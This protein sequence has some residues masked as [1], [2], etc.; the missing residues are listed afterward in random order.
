[1]LPNSE[2]SPVPVQRLRAFLARLEGESRGY[3]VVKNPNLWANIERGGDWDLLV[4]DLPSAQ[5]H[6]VETLGRPERIS[7]RSYV[8]SHYFDWGE[9]DLLSGIE[10]RGVELVDRDRV[11]RSFRRHGE[12]WRINSLAYEA[13]A[14]WV[15][16]LLYS[17]TFNER[18][19]T[20]IQAAVANEADDLQSEL[21]RVFG[22]DLAEEMLSLASSQRLQQSV[23]MTS[24]LRRTALQR[25]AAQYPIRFSLRLFR[26]GWCECRLR[27]RPALPTVRVGRAAD[28]CVVTRWCLSHGS[29]V[30]GLALWSGNHIGKWDQDQIKGL[31]REGVEQA[32][33]FMQT[34]D[35]GMAAR[36]LFEVARLRS[37]GWLIVYRVPQGGTWWAC[38]YRGALRR[39]AYASDSL[40]A[41]LDHCLAASVK[42][43]ISESL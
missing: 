21:Q 9:I 30:P 22:D 20:V 7:R 36:T 10:W 18:Y 34:S 39:S 32:W 37:N 43:E 42:R 3:V 27:I 17:G 4:G 8:C 35:R 25:A 5:A 19:E 14:C 40:N 16:P 38:D 2:K 29:A 26:H 41:V 23:K 31:T 28:L 33:E 6:L 11:L 24:R 15:S 12:G 1:M 13:I